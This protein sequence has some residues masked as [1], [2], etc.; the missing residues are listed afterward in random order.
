MAQNVGK[1]RFYIDH[2]LWLYMSKA[3]SFSDDKISL[4]Q[5]N[6]VNIK[7]VTRDHDSISV[8]VPRLA[9][10][11]YVAFLGHNGGTMYPEWRDDNN[12]QVQNGGF[13]NLNDYVNAQPYGTGMEVEFNGFSIFLFDDLPDDRY[14]MK[15]YMAGTES[16]VGAISIGSYF[17]MPHS[18][19]LS[20][21]LSYEQGVKTIETIGGVSL[22]NR[23]W[24]NPLWNDLAPWE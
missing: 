16:R 18:P 11:T 7:A 24:Q 1:P 21:T 2:G 6:P 23:T 14:Y 13:T 9:P 8:T 12:S 22:S 20:L 19:D 3:H 10:I 4:I 17:D 15:G 5:L